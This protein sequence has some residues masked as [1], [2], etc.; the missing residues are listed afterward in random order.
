MCTRVRTR[1]TGT[2]INRRGNRRIVFTCSSRIAHVHAVLERLFSLA[3][4]LYPGFR[5]TITTLTQAIPRLLLYMTASSFD[6]SS[7]TH[8]K[9][10]SHQLD[11]QSDQDHYEH[12]SLGPHLLPCKT[13]TSPL[14]QPPISDAS[15]ALHLAYASPI[16]A[17]HAYR[18]SC[19]K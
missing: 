18:P 9:T 6:S 19:N 15:A 2:T 3:T 16:Q 11:P 5:L 12:T 10:P 1:T 4:T 8:S 13:F 17:C 14:F 7:G